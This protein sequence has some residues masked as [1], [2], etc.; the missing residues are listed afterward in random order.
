MSIFRLAGLRHTFHKVAGGWRQR[1]MFVDERALDTLPPR[2]A[3]PQPRRGRTPKRDRSECTQTWSGDET[4]RKHPRCLCIF[5]AL[6]SVVTRAPHTRRP[7]PDAIPIGAP[8]KRRHPRA[9]FPPGARMFFGLLLP[10][11]SGDGVAVRGRPPAPPGHSSSIPE[12]HRKPLPL[13]LG[14]ARRL[15]RSPELAFS[16]HFRRAS[17]Q[18]PSFG[19][20]LPSHS[21]L[22]LANTG[23]TSLANVFAPAPVLFAALLG[24][25]VGVGSVCL[26]NGPGVAA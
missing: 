15:S 2:R 7:L 21:G 25:G 16:D 9:S 8:R 17:R 1:G 4:K 12:P 3:T 24:L 18:R 19:R 10:S 23:S 14:H 6:P 20:G 13:R 22:H 11:G 26:Y 5:I